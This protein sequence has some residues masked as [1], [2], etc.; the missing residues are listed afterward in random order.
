MLNLDRASAMLAEA[1]S[2]AQVLGLIDS[3]WFLDQE[4]QT[5]IE[6]C[7]FVCNPA[8]ALQLGTK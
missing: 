6:Q 7:R 8:M 3:G 4:Q 2:S 5:P 1:G